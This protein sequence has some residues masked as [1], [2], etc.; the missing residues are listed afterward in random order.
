MLISFIGA[1][2][3]GV[4]A[5]CGS[6]AVA[7]APQVCVATLVSALVL[8]FLAAFLLEGRDLHGRHSYN[9]HGLTLDMTHGEMLSKMSAS[10]AIDSFETKKPHYIGGHSDPETGEEVQVFFIDH[11]DGIVGHR[12]VLSKPDNSS[13]EST[14]KRSEEHING[15]TMDYSWM[16]NNQK[17]FNH[18][19]KKNGDVSA[20]G[21]SAAYDWYYN[22]GNTN[23]MCGGPVTDSGRLLDDV[24]IWYAGQPGG[25]SYPFQPGELASELGSCA[26]DLNG[27]GYSTS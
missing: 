24:G 14:T 13:T 19:D 6:A 21:K 20:A 23:R 2:S 18:T 26:A 3:Y 12:A 22:H 8:D 1:T 9:P 15:A 10:L 27:A 25:G 7:Y 11:G 17:R 4:K 16:Y 5:T